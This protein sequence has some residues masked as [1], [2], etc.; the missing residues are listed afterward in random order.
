MGRLKPKLTKI[1][2]LEEADLVL[3]EI[4]LTERELEA[5]D[6][7]AQKKIAGIKEDTVK[8]GEELRK[9]IT[10]L[11]SLLGA[12]AEYNKDEFF[13]DKKTVELTFGCF[14]YRKSTSISIKKT[15]LDLLKKLGLSQ[16]VRVKEEPDK[17]K[18]KELK[19]EELAQI[20]AVRKI[21]N[22]FFC[23]ANRENI[24]KELLKSQL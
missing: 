1:N 2:S 19:D 11:S 12:Y 17:E 5:I 3:K 13:K 20:E 18:L 14:G 7:N 23:E 22:D 4:G 24:N 8:Q 10:G 16:F 21:K 9:R 6:A 15:T